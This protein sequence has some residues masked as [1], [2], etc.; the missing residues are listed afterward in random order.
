MLFFEAVPPEWI[1]SSERPIVWL[2]ERR[3]KKG[4]HYVPPS[5]GKSMEMRD[6]QNENKRMS[7]SLNDHCRERER[8]KKRWQMMMITMAPAVEV[9]KD[10][11]R[12]IFSRIVF[13][14]H[15][16]MISYLNVFVIFQLWLIVN[17][18]IIIIRFLTFSTCRRL[19][20]SSILLWW[21][22]WRRR[23]THS[24]S[25]ARFLFLSVSL[26]FSFHYTSRNWPTRK[27]MTECM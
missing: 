8:E 20:C 1:S 17:E 14:L 27:R 13:E 26:L 11:K 6:N 4:E 21:W 23:L 22:R 15:V 2:N 16:G 19:T 25:L 7:F 24:L 18:M 9:W 10:L 12:T 3:G 5:Q